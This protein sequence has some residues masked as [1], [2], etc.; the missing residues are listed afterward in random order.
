MENAPINALFGIYMAPVIQDRKDP[1]NRLVWIGG[2]GGKLISALLPEDFGTR[3]YAVRRADAIK[4]RL[5]DLRTQKK[6]TKIFDLGLSPSD[7]LRH[8]CGAEGNA[9]IQVARELIEILPATVINR[10]LYYLVEDYWKRRSGWPDLLVYRD[11]QFFFA[12]VKS[13][14][15][16]LSDNQMR[17]NH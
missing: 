15:D 7:A 4:K 10:I 12:E 17:W 2:V 13:S 1:R 3:G 9:V 8:Y 14:S 6:L 11:E 16:R 5:S